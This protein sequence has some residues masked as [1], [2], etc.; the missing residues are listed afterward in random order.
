MDTKQ[1]I[2]EK[3]DDVNMAFYEGTVE[4]MLIITVHK[5]N[6]LI[7]QAYDSNCNGVINIALDL[8]K[9]QMLTAIKNVTT[10]VNR[11]G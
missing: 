1:I 7:H 4:G 10:E 11:N 9:D 8:A 3:L 5:G 6:F 2:K